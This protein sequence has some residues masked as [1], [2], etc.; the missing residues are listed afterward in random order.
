MS[1][2][3]LRGFKDDIDTSKI[4]IGSLRKLDSGGQMAGVSYTNEN[5]PFVIQTPLM[6]IPYDFGKGYN[7][8]RSDYLTLS[9]GDYN[10]EAKLNKF[11]ENMKNI[12]KH[13]IGH[14]I[15]N[16]E[17]W[18]PSTVGKSPEFIEQ[19]MEDAFN[20]FVKPS[21]KYP[22]TMKLK[23]PYDEDNKKYKDIMIT[24]LK[25]DEEYDFN[26]IKHKLK[27]AF[28]RICF[29]ITTIYNINKHFGITTKATKI[30]ISFPVKEEDDFLSDS[31]DEIAIK[32]KKVELN[33]EIDNE[34][35]KE[36]S[37]TKEPVKDSEEEEEED[38]KP[39]V[40]T[41]K[42]VK[43]K[44]EPEESEDSEESD[45]KNDDDSDDDSED[46]EPVKPV[47]KTGKKTVSKKK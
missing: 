6:Q 20:P 32:T 23:I 17:I 37:D 29:R 47:K 28:V 42:T 24:D 34:I 33:D 16:N 30:K 46:D 9:F 41:K 10:S 25:T 21:A 14:A 4:N 11:H 36:I 2:G 45:K 1:S 3:T 27:G 44:A 19:L 15:K 31:D 18:L 7:G 13:V 12:E 8:E 43:K 35:L 40:V 22:P 5:K 39:V 26:E 38:E